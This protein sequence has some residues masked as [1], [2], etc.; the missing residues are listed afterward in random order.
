MFGEKT[1]LSMMKR[2]AN[3][4]GDFIKVTVRY[5]NGSR[6]E[7]FH[8]AISEVLEVKQRKEIHN[9]PLN[10]M[11]L[12]LTEHLLHIFKGCYLKRMLS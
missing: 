10:V 12:V 9:S 8:A 5:K 6:Q 2:E 4:E 7:N 11:I 1:L 3:L